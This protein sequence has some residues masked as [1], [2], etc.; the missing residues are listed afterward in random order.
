M[1]GTSKRFAVL[2]L[3]A[4]LVALPASAGAT[5]AY[6]K[7]PSDPHVYVAE[8]NGKGAQAIGAGD[9][10]HVSP[11]GEFVVYE[12]GTPGLA[13]SE[14]ELYSVA[15][16]KTTTLLGE[17]HE[18][19]A[20]AWAP[21][22]RTV[23]A[24]RGPQAGP[25]TLVLVEVETGK[26]TTIAKGYTGGFSFSPDGSGLV[27]GVGR[28]VVYPAEGALHRYTLATGASVAL[29][30]GDG[31]R[32]PLWG[33]DHQI[34]FSKEIGTKRGSPPRFDLFLI[35]EDGGGVRQLT[36]T[37]FP[38]LSEGLEPTAWT[39]DG[40]QVL[41]QFGGQGT[42]Y[43][44]AVNAATGAE[45]PLV[46]GLTWGFYGSALSPDGKTV[47]GPLGSVP[48][49]PHAKVATVPFAGGRPKVLVTDASEPSWGG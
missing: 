24:L 42:S 27:Y 37:S 32:L 28:S 7:P 22:S 33:P 8:D 49:D 19:Y 15:T 29:T 14:M 46:K 23:A 44:V 26:V 10:P 6:V 13:G 30:H 12:R 17:W 41:A 16:G 2:V 34:V 20:L 11:D 45:R 35:N 25:P 18:S 40:K 4:I 38:P 5:L 9:R 31:A 48:N 47:L 36:H 39:P 43:A 1:P 21:D 3:V